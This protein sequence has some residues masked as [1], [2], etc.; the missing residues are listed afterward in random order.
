ML[1]LQSR[2]EIKELEDSSAV[3]RIIRQMFE[4]INNCIL[5]I[6]TN[7]VCYFKHGCFLRFEDEFSFGY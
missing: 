4:G 5:S 2:L 3:V 7:A 6:N 1:S